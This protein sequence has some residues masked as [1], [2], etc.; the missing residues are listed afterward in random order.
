MHIAGA[1]ITGLYAVA[2]LCVV[3]VIERRCRR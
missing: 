2:V 1:V 3:V